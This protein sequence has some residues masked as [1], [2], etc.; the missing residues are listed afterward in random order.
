MYVDYSGNDPVTVAIVTAAIIGAI[1]GGVTYVGINLYNGTAITWGG[2]AKSIIVGAISGAAS[3]GIGQIINGANVAICAATQT[4]TQTQINLILALPQA[5]MHGIA[6]G[7]IQGIS[8]GD[9]G[10]S[11][12]TAAISSLAGS[13]FGEIGGKVG[14]YTNTVL[15]KSLFGAVA[16]GVTSYLQGGNFWEGA[17]IG[18]TVGLLNHAG[19]KLYPAIDR[20]FDDDDQQQQS[21]SMEEMLQKKLYSMKIGSSMK[22][23]ELDFLDKNASYGIKSIT[24]V[25]Q[26]KFSIKPTAIGSWKGIKDNA[27]LTIEPN[28]A[29]TGKYFDKGV[30][31]I[32]GYKVTQYIT[33]PMQIG[34]SK[35]NT[36][37][38]NG[39]NAY[40][41]KTPNT[42]S[43]WDLRN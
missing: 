16:G 15:G 31:T 2:L 34:N 25:S 5:L 27:Y 35:T 37:I 1:I 4:L 39:N 10:Q 9:A 32:T 8:G 36:Y 14:K 26:T 22:G 30:K 24:R 21:K 28:K 12:I 23:S 33:P 3:G 42:I 7:I 20:M 41:Q 19:E 40:Y 6:Q 17:A 43:S 13:G 29:I 11:F 18:L 38:I